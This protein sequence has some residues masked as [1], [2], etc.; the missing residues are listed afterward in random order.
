MLTM[1]IM[2]I[3]LIMPNILS[4]LIINPIISGRRMIVGIAGGRHGEF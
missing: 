2:L 3:G 4:N 1:L